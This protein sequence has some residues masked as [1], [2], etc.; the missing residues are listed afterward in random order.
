M[1]THSVQGAQ[2]SATSANQGGT[3]EAMDVEGGDMGSATSSGNDATGNEGTAK[4]KY[5]A[6]SKAKGKGKAKAQDREEQGQENA[7]VDKGKGK[8]KKVAHAIKAVKKTPVQEMIDHIKGLVDQATLGYALMIVMDNND[9]GA[10][11]MMQCQQI[12]LHGINRQ[13]I[14]GRLFEGCGGPWPPE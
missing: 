2:A 11:P 6:T 8:E 4:Q 9:M 14:H 12:N 7:P 3:S 10:G 1:D 5:E 13:V